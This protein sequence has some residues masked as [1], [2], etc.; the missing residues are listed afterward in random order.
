[1]AGGALATPVYRASCTLGY[2]GC[3]RSLFHHHCYKGRPGGSP[4]HLFISHNNAVVKGRPV[5]FPITNWSPCISGNQRQGV[6]T[7]RPYTDL[8]FALGTARRAPTL[9]T[10]HT[11][12]QGGHGG[13]PLQ[14]ASTLGTARRAPTLVTRHT[15]RQGGHGGPPLRM[16]CFSFF[17]DL[18]PRMSNLEPISSSID[19]PRPFC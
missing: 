8:P 6:P 9:V 1:M 17:F 3:R 15:S 7:E 19:L 16:P 5:Y 4:C 18:E 12:R 13:P 10:R 11:S 14:F 2:A